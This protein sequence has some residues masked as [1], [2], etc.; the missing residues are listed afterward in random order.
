MERSCIRSG[1]NDMAFLRKYQKTL[2]LL[3]TTA[4]LI[5]VCVFC[6]VLILVGLD[7]RIKG[8]LQAIRLGESMPSQVEYIL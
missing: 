1:S 6:F 5:Y 7:P 8:R 4:I 2:I 3:V